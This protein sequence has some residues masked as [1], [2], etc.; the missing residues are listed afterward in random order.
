MLLEKALAKMF[1]SYSRL[2]SGFVDEALTDLS[3][4]PCEK[5]TIAKKV[6]SAP[7][8]KG[9]TH[10]SG[11][12]LIIAGQRTKFWEEFK[13]LGKTGSGN[14]MACTKMETKMGGA[15]SSRNDAVREQY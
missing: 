3:S 11:G 4:F 9:T 2:C 15:G 10:S 12:S 13:A 6:P 5:I 14:L 7:S 8:N 1:G